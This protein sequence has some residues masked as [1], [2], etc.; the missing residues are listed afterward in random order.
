MTAR[1]LFLLLLICFC[2]VP[3]SVSAEEADTQQVYHLHA[4]AMHGAP[5][6][7]PDFKHLDYANP[8]APK[9]GA[10]K[11]AVTGS[12][13][14]L[15]KHIVTG[16]NTS[17]GLELI[18]DKLMQRVW[19]EPFTLYGLVAE[20][21]DIPED[22]SWITF[23]INPEARFHDGERMDA[24][25]LVFSYEMYR[26]HG[27][28]VRR[29]VYGFVD[30]VTVI[31]DQTVRFDFGEGHDAETALILAMMPVL[32][33]HYW[34]E[35]SFQKTTLAP[36]L[37]SGPYRI[38]KVDPGREIVYERVKDYWAKDHPVNV[39]HYNFDTITYS[40]YRDDN[41]ALEAFK[42]GE[43]DL[44]REG[45]AAKWHTGYD[46]PDI[47]SG[48][49]LREELAH[50]RPEYVRSLIFNTRRAPFN[51][52]KVREALQYALD[53]EWMNTH[54]FHGAFRRIDSFFPNSS[55]A[56]TGAPEGEE[57]RILEEHI[58]D[59]P[60]D[61]LGKPW[62]PPKT[63]GSGPPGMRQNLRTASALLKEA[64]WIVKDSK[65]VN[66]ETGRP[67]S[68]E[69]LLGDPN[70]EKIAMQ[71]AR[72]LQRLGIDATIR[73]VDS[74]QFTGRLD[75]FEYDMTVFRW[76]NSL[77]PGNEQVNYWGSAAA[78]RHGSRNYPGVSSP[79]IDAI[80]ESIARAP[81]RD[82]LVAR[83]RALDRALQWGFYTIPLYYLGHD[84][85]AYRARL[86]R[87]DTTPLYGMVVE[88]WWDKNAQTDAQAN[89]SEK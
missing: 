34:T 58:A 31:D 24:Q 76:V 32:P 52:R 70:D 5:K 86:G 27:H 56:A 73:T 62:T 74:A 50:G 83:A 15:N 22:R 29:R 88:T 47:D 60:E 69:I 41:V 7:G 64:G 45:D 14:S 54:L 19:D 49:V 75:S 65:R 1:R 30:K 63:D 33:S 12:F 11:R 42:A 16:S 38:A 18:E 87:P 55:L 4:L 84:L 3:F 35:E 71:F 43:Y 28:P 61:V 85:V 6:Y 67:F 68:F 89:N 53:F 51:D 26:E 82:A 79:A 13:D 72:A 17:D 20:S 23:H 77:S 44:R 66:A 25:D 37:G 59:L 21:I 46:F 40:Y 8:D 39:G 9:G 36:P 78:E 10:L 57:R 81:G 80:A 2:A 48:D